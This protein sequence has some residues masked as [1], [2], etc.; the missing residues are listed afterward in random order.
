MNRR[1]WEAGFRAKAGPVLDEI[2]RRVKK[3]PSGSTP[4][5]N[6]QDVYRETGRKLSRRFIAEAL[7]RNAAVA[8]VEMLVEIGWY[9]RVLAG[10]SWS[11]SSTM[12]TLNKTNKRA[13]TSEGKKIARDLDR[14]AAQLAPI[15]RDTSLQQNVWT[16]LLRDGHYKI[17]PPGRVT[18][19]TFFF[20]EILR[21][22]AHELRDAGSAPP[23]PDPAD[24]CALDMAR[25]VRYYT[26]AERIRSSGELLSALVGAA[27]GQRLTPNAV[28]KKLQRLRNAETIFRF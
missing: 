10:R 19:T 7:T 9:Y 5:Q 8:V 27:L 20:T 6:A 25:C 14:L 22:I 21:R 23:V 3:P 28:E 16:A 12:R 26:G 24:L 15:E 4:G 17:E 18:V 1:S 11:F 13:R 2:A